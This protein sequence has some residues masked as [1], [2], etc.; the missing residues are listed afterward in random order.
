MSMP[1]Q[2]PE[3][4]PLGA[5]APVPPLAPPPVRRRRRGLWLG[6]FI[7]FIAICGVVL[8][9]YVGNRI[10]PV[11]L[12]VGVT[13]AMLPVP[14]LVS[15]FLW[16]DRYDP[17]PV[18]LLL[19]CFLWGAFVATG[20]AL[21]V[22]TTAGH[23]FEQW[24]IADDLVG[25][26]VAPIIEES[27][28]ALFP[29][30]LFIFA[31]RRFSGITDGIVFC[32][33]S[34]TGFAMVE[35]ILYLGGYGYAS[36][37]AENGFAGGALAVE[38]MFIGRVLFTGFG[39]PLFTSMTGIGLGIAARS[40]DKRV[41]VLAPA[42]G[43]LLAMCLHAAWNFM[44]SLAQD[45]PYYV[46]YGYFAVF[47]PIFLTVVGVVIWVRSSEGRL[48]ERI[49]PAYAVAGW[50]SPPEVL[51]LGTLG[52]RLSARAWARRVAG[53]AGAA[54]MRNYQY[55]ATRLAL[56]RDGLDRGL[57]VQPHEVAEA[58]AEEQQLLVAV[59]AYRSVFTRRDPV[60]PPAHW[61]GQ[62]YHVVFPDGVSRPVE[63]PPLPVVPVP[64]VVQ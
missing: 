50:F 22:N 7:V 42:V 9:G 63:A 17:E 25:V 59:D 11:A 20:V 6:L 1:P 18:S 53:D 28:K 12:G 29:I 44:A 35:N 60:T 64:F 55:A 32:G 4:M 40:A 24:G 31:R 57:R 48:T 37:A 2:A 21:I 52:R 10:G 26:V 45:S 51:A 33:L 41:R 34:A 30:L 16:L 43:L 38:A 5:P 19:F 27:M 8:L 54:A 46:L 39:H 3:P 58:V 56:L 47:M 23:L 62:R 14:V 36:G 49:L 15:C 61:D 13:A